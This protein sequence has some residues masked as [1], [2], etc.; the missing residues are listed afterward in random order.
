MPSLLRAGLCCKCNYWRYS[1]SHH[2][3][4]TPGPTHT[5]LRGVIVRGGASR[6]G[7]TE[8]GIDSNQ[9]WRLEVTLKN[10]KPLHL[11]GKPEARK[12]AVCEGQPAIV[13]EAEWVDGG[14]LVTVVSVFTNL[15]NLKVAG[16]RHRQLYAVPRGREGPAANAFSRLLS[17]ASFGRGSAA[18]GRS[19]RAIAHGDT[20]DTLQQQK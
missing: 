16:A 5:L 1:L 11:A 8:R 4:W 12:P 2:I 20:C 7:S 13:V 17:L 15:S 6:T 10:V 9:D 14:G 19:A 3:P 18:L